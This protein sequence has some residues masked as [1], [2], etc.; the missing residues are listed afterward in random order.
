MAATHRA[1]IVVDVQ[2]TFCEGGALGVDGG[3]AVAEAIAS[4]TAAH[5]DRYDLAVTTQ[6][7]H[8]GPGGH[9]SDA[10][11]PEDTSPPHREAG[12]AQPALHPALARA[13]AEPAEQAGTKCA[14]YS[15]A[16]S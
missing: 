10:P 5:R 3:N 13:P 12:T 9:F 7:W 2:P 6:D 1:L 8:I 16:S 11:D 14:A 4:Y 15:G